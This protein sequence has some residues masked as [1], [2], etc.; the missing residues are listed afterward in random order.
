[1]SFNYFNHKSKTNKCLEN[2][3]GLKLG[4]Q[5]VTEVIDSEQNESLPTSYIVNF[6]LQEYNLV[7]FLSLIRN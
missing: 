4:A 2:F 7:T 1:M 3:L 5:I 6:T